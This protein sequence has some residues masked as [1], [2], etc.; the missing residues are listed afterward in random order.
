MVPNNSDLY[1]WWKSILLFFVQERLHDSKE[2]EMGSDLPN[3]LQQ[4]IQVKYM[5]T[6][7]AF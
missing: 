6:L 3:D 4:V 2:W 5:L 1:Y 7:Q